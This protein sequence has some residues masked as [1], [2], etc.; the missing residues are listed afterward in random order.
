MRGIGKFIASAVVAGLLSGAAQAGELTFWS[1]RQ[2]DR[3]AYQEFFAAFTKKNPDITVKFE[4]FEPTNYPT[5]LSTALTGGK[6]PDLMQV[7]AYGA[8]ETIA[9]PGYLEAINAASVPELGSIAPGA[10]RGQ[11]LTDDGKI[12]AVPFA[13]QTMLVIYNTELFAKHGVKIPET[14]DD[15]LTAAKTLKAAGV[16]PFAN[17]TATAWQNETIVG[18]LLSSAMGRQFEA[19]ILAGKATFED[20]RFTDALARLESL[21]DYFAPNYVGIDYAS[22]QQLFAAGQAAMFAG[23]SFEI[24]NFRKMNP[25]MKLDVFASPAV[26]KGEDTLVAQFLDGGYAVN[27]KSPAKVDAMKLLRF[28]ASQEYGQ[29]FANKLGNF[30]PIAGVAMDDPLLARVSALN[31]KSMSYLLLVHFRYKEPNGS[32][33]LQSN[34]QKMMAGKATPAEVGAELTKGIAT[35]YA[36]FK[37]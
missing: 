22:S 30:S 35:Y 28:M 6:G 20:K 23:G 15:L 37:K 3:A 24:A 26:A 10:L 19:D 27:A 17:G 36:P 31:A 1:W 21:K 2:E 32:V 34:V 4:T 9:R 12:Y 33:L 14:W 13:T 18:A 25:A 5:I 29:M 8:F 11:T 16:T 7:R